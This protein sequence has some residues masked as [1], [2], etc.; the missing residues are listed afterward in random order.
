[1]PPHKEPDSNRVLLVQCCHPPEFFFIVEQLRKRH[2][3]WK[4]DALLVEHPQLR[5]YLEFFPYFENVYFF[6]TRL[7]EIRIPYIQ[8]IFPLLNRGYR[9]VKSAARRLPFSPWEVDYSGNLRSLR[10][11]R[12]LG[13]LFVPLAHPSPEFGHYL[14]RFPHHPPGEKILLVE[15]CHPSL[16][17]LA[18]KRLR[19]LIPPEAEVCRSGKGSLWKLWRKA[20]RQSYDSAIVFFSGEKGF[21]ALKILPFL[22]RLPRILVVNENGHCFYASARSLAS[23]LYQRVHHGMS[24]P[25]S[26]PRILFIQTEE[27]SFVTRA[28]RIL[29]GPNLFPM[30]DILLVCREEDRPSFQDVPHITRILTYSRESVRH[31]LQLWMRLIEFGPD[32]VSAIF[33]GRA[34]FRKQKLFFFL[35]PV[36]RHLVFNPQLDCYNLT[37]RTVLR[38]LRKQPLLFETSDVRDPAAQVLLI[39]TESDSDVKKAIETLKNPKVVNHARISVF[40]R[41]DKREIFESIPEVQQVFTYQLGKPFRNLET[42]RKMVRLRLHVVAAILSG[43][44]VFRMQKLLFFL[45]PARHRLV[46]NQ[47][48]DCFYLTK[49]GIPDFPNLSTTRV[50]LRN[51]A[52]MLLFLP[53]FAYLVTW[54]TVL[55]YRHRRTVSRNDEIP[56]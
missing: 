52:K 32:L 1:M 7:P 12:L 38:I 37:L 40:C 41:E 35:L 4:F 45:L 44:S 28:I 17:S 14:K 16:I 42:V 24:F 26:S 3:Q 31:N 55:K 23:F 30:S 22:L 39:Q 33:S 8:I 20:R 9:R 18:Q 53:R 21:A 43:R 50:F 15:S 48:L 56:S 27:P 47:N 29:K 13:S 6:R 10:R 49:E 54:I 25:R 51:I 34:V 5:F 46:F 11:L 36:R 2:P 19:P